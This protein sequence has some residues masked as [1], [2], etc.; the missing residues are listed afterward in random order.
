MVKENRLKAVYEQLLENVSP[1][2]G[3]FKKELEINEIVDLLSKIRNVLLPEYVHN[4]G[5]NFEDLEFIQ[6]KIQR[7]MECTSEDSSVAFDDSIKFIQK[8]P[9]LREMVIQDIQAAFLKDPAAKSTEEIAIAYPG[10]YAIMVHRISHEFYKMGYFL[11]ARLFSEHAHSKTGI[12]IHPGAKIGRSFFIDHGTGIVIGETTTIGNNVTIYQGVT[13]GA[14]SFHHDENG[15][16]IKG[17][18]RH[19]TIEDE[20]TIYAGATILGGETIIGKGSIIGG[21][22]WLTQS[23]APNSKAISKFQVRILTS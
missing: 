18:K 6:K 7:I 17:L 10:I 19:P 16:I 4:H 13:L 11:I 9:N 1:I 8:I 22:V 3:T 14:F 15:E 5:I 2:G 21:N 23:V 20:V 12:D